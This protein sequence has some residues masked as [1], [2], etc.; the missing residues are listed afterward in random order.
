M[1]P[2]A[3][4]WAPGTT[5]TLRVEV[6]SG[7]LHPVAFADLQCTAHGASRVAARTDAAGTALVSLDGPPGPIVVEVGGERVEVHP[8]P[9]GCVT[10]EL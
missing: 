8:G 3:T 4:V 5:R 10:I 9:H 2:V 6:V 1:S 7:D